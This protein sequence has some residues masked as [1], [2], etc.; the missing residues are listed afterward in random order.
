MLK[1]T[2]KPG[3]RQ[4]LETPPTI[5]LTNARSSWRELGEKLSADQKKGVEDAIKDVREKLNGTDAD[6]IKKATEEL[7]SRFQAISAELY[8]QAASQKPGPQPGDATGSSGS[9]GGSTAKP[10]DNVVDADFEVVDD[11]KKKS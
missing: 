6:A 9:T 3:K 2:G 5:W 7:Q 8:K 4:R 1:R 11:D 10:D